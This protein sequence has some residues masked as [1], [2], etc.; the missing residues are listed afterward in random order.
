MWSC[1]ISKYG[2]NERLLERIHKKEFRRF[3]QIQSWKRKKEI[4]ENKEAE[5]QK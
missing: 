1:R 2:N 4:K 5:T 3:N